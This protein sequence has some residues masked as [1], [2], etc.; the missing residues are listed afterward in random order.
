MKKWGRINETATNKQSIRHEKT[1]WKALAITSKIAV[2]ELAE[3]KI[4]ELKWV[5]Q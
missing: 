4:L 5:S 3:I 1:Y 2:K